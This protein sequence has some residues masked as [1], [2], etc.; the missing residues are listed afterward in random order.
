MYGKLVLIKRNGEDGDFF[1]IES[2]ELTIGRFVIASG[3]QL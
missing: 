1:D 2:P 3:K